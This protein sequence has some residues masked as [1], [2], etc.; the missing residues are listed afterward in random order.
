MSFSSIAKAI[1]LNCVCV[2]SHRHTCTHG[3]DDGHASYLLYPEN[4]IPH[5]NAQKNSV[6]CL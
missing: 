6:L 3:C 5:K 4:Q 1:G 2:L